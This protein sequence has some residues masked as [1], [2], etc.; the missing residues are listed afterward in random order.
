MVETQLSHILAKLGAKGRT[1]IVREGLRHGISALDQVFG[2]PAG[3]GGA[4]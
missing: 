1:E 4:S 3:H 2:G